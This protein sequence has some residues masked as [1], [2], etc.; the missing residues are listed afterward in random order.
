METP[1]DSPKNRDCPNQFLLGVNVCGSLSSN[2]IPNYLCLYFVSIQCSFLPKC[3]LSWN[4]CSQCP[5]CFGLC[6]NKTVANFVFNFSLCSNLTR[7]RGTKQ[8]WSESNRPPWTVS[9]LSDCLFFGK[10]NPFWT[11]FIRIELIDCCV[12]I[13][14]LK[15][16]VGAGTIAQIPGIKCPILLILTQCNLNS[17]DLLSAV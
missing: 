11:E 1:L 3:P 15:F 6:S 13:G 9:H 8:K 5:Q 2:T 17:Q 7:G 14:W 16:R 10:V 12:D 4:L